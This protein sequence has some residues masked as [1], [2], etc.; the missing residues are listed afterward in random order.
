MVEFAGNGSQIHGYLATPEGSGPG[1]VVIQEWWG[2]VEHIADVCDRFAAEGFVALAPDL[3]AGKTT[4]EPDEAGKLLMAM[5]LDEAGKAMGGA[6]DY[7]R[8]HDRVQPKKIGSVGF[9]MGGNLALLVAT[10]RPLDA[11]VAF[12]PFPF[13]PVDVAKLSGPALAHIAE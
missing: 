1:I 5:E 2:L 13:A 4:A 9:C 3:Y 12:Y 10:L 11:S 8:G 7:L 6:V